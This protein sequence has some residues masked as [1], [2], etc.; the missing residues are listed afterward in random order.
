MAAK[1]GAVVMTGFVVF[2]GALLMVIGLVNVF[3]G[4]VALF[5]DER[6]VMT[7]TKLVLVDVTGWGWFLL[8]FGLLLMAVGGGLLVAQTWAR[9]TA[10]LLVCL[11]AV[12]Q[13]LWL[14]AYPVWS[15]LMIALDTIVLFAL[16]ARWHDVRDKLGGADQTPW[17][18]DEEA[19]LSAA[20]Q[21]RPPL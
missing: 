19:E 21:R 13:V 12:V 2:A 11:H 20:E 3:E 9:I 15:L 6:L 7:P 4:F 16:T 5:S 14:G 17:S 10:I 1:K 18:K 8:I